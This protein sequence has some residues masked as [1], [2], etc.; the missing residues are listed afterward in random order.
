LFRS[1]LADVKREVAS[2]GFGFDRGFLDQHERPRDAALGMLTG[3]L[4]EV[5][6]ERFAAAIKTVS[7]RA[8][9]K[10]VPI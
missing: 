10:E 9:E 5:R 3:G 1:E 8:P 7:V 4:P 6:I 2:D